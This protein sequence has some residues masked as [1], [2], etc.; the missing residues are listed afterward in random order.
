M[1]F[2]PAQKL[3]EMINKPIITTSANLSDYPSPYSL[4]EIYKQYGDSIGDK[5]SVIVDIGE[6]PKND[7]STLIDLTDNNKIVKR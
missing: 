4:E 5:V 1:D 2:Q 7:L 6:L 3:C